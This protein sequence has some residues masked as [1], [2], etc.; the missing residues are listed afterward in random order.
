MVTMAMTNADVDCNDNKSDHRGVGEVNQKNESQQEN[1]IDRNSS[2]IRADPQFGSVRKDIEK[3]ES[4]PQ[5]ALNPI[6]CDKSSPEVAGQ[7]RLQQEGDI[8]PT[9]LD[10]TKENYYQGRSQYQGQYAQNSRDVQDN[11]YNRSNRSYQYQQGQNYGYQK[12][13]ESGYGAYGG[14]SAYY[15]ADKS[16]IQRGQGSYGYARPDRSGYGQGESQTAGQSR[17]PADRNVGQSYERQQNYMSQ[18]GDQSFNRGGTGQADKSSYYREGYQ[19]AN[20]Q[21]SNYQRAQPQPS[22]TGGNSYGDS[23]VNMASN[24]HYYGSNQ[25][26]YA[27]EPVSKQPDRQNRDEEVNLAQN[28]KDENGTRSAYNGA[29]AQKYQISGQNSGTRQYPQAS[30]YPRQSQG[31]GQQQYASQYA[32]GTDSS[33]Y[34]QPDQRDWRGQRGGQG[35]STQQGQTYAAQN[36]DFSR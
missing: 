14:H 2:P 4:N 33:Q 29:P 19:Q 12:R 35:Q 26:R 15:A 31:Y 34:G 3:T 36:S 20:G 7:P 24:Q 9:T 18:R 11:D 23:S 5:S 25:Q 16:E 17:Y 28:S 8:N 27:Q 6:A 32:Y 22:K 10:E 21:N 1:D 13:Q 30:A